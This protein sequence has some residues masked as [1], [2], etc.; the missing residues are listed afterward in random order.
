MLAAH[1]AFFNLSP[2]TIVSQL[3]SRKQAF[4]QFVVELMAG[5]APVQ[6]KPMFGGFG[7]YLDGLMFALIAQ[8]QLYF[9][10]DEQSVPSFERRG[11]GPFTYEAKAKGSEQKS[12]VA[13][14]KYF[15]APPEVLDDSQAMAQWA[16]QAYDC[17]LRQQKAKAAS[18]RKVPVKVAKPSAQTPAVSADAGLVT[19]KNLG[20]K[21]QA[22]LAKAGIHTEDDLR[23]TGS[24]MAYVRTKAVWPAASLNLLWALEGALTGRSWQSVAES[25]RA[26]LL[27]ALE[28]V[29][30]HL[31]AKSGKK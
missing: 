6:A 24:V 19:L 14:L 17:A 7:I 5:F 10:A 9:K 13:S 16:R 21:S 3:A 15:V 20:P 25:D 18:K 8:D 1:L 28:D 29:E 27:M 30:H 12:R 11:L 31:H 22:M 23:K 4:A 2:L 26:S